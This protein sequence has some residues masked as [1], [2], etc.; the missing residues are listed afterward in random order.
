M[1]INEDGY[2]DIIAAGNFFDV[3]PQFCRVDAS[4]GHILMNDKKGNFIE[5]PVAKTGVDLLGQVRDIISFKYKKG[6]GILFLENDDFPVMYKID[7][8]KKD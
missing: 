8:D 7:Q 1:D 4:H 6:D 5:M 2:P 3:L